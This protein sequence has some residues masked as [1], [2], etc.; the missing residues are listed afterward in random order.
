M[1]SNILKL[2]LK[3]VDPV[4][5]AIIASLL[6]MLIMLIVFVPFMLLFS[7]IGLGAATESFGAA[8]AIVGSGIFMII[9]VPLIYGAIVFVI[10]LIATALLNF[11]LK[12]TGGLDVDFEKVGF[13]FEAT[14]ANQGRIEQ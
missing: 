2:K 9:F 7:A 1:N 8:G 13:D 10:T 11:I 5:Y 4:K 14:Q 3:R 6:T 12:K